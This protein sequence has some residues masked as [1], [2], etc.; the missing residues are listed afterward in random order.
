MNNYETL[1]ELE[2]QNKEEII[3]FD[4]EGLSYIINSTV[5]GEVALFNIEF[6]NGSHDKIISQSDFN[7]NYRY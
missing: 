7:E 2:K 4:N 1:K 5:K 6:D 3:V